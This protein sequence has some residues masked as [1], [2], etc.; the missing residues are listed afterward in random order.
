MKR[1]LCTVFLVLFLMSCA[2]AAAE[3]VQEIQI[4]GVFEVKTTI[5]EGYTYEGS[6]RSDILYIGYLTS[7]DPSKVKGYITIAYDEEAEGRTLNDF[8]EDEM[9]GLISLFMQDLPGAEVTMGETG[10]GTR[11]LIFTT[12]TGSESRVDIMTIWHG[13]Q[14]AIMLIP[15]AGMDGIPEDQVNTMLEFLTNVEIKTLR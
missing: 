4:N 11:L 13:Y 8:S 6:Y 14:V 10:K 1:I 3:S 12:N 7:D 2:C 9:A 5:P 15:G